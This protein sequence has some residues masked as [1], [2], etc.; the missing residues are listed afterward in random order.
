MHVGECVCVCVCACALV[1]CV[2]GGARVLV[3]TRVVCVVAHVVCS[4]VCVWYSVCMCA[5][6]CVLCGCMHECLL[7]F[8][9]LLIL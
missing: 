2:C 3:C 6:F 1:W 4:I 9:Y 5:H 8:G 7:F